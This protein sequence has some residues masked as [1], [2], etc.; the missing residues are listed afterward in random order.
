MQEFFQLVRQLIGL[1][2]PQLLEYRLV[3]G[4]IGIFSQHGVQLCILDPVDFQRIEHQRRCKDRHLF[5]CILHE[6][7]AFGIRGVLVIPQPGIRHQPPARG[8]DRLV[9]LHTL[10]QAFSVQTGQPALVF[11]CEIRTGLF[12]PLHIPRE[13]RRVG[14]RVKIAQIP[15][16][17]VAKIFS[18]GA[19]GFAVKNRSREGKL[20]GGP[21]KSK[22]STHIRAR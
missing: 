22:C 11:G 20:H 12:Q 6:L 8:A 10:Q 2:C 14:G 3:T 18:R 21:F 4:Q 9:F 7:C 16:R 19:V 13:F 17:Q 1:Q 5:L 15:F